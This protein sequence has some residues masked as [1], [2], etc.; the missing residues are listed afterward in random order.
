MPDSWKKQGSA[1]NLEKTNNIVVNSLV[2]D[3]FTVRK[4]ANDMTVSSLNV[5]GN[6]NIKGF[7]FVIK[8]I[9]GNNL[10]ISNNITLDGH[11]YFDSS[12]NVFLKGF[13]DNSDNYFLGLNNSNPQATLDISSN[14]TQSIFVKTTDSVNKNVLANTKDDNGIMLYADDSQSSVYFFN[15][16]SN[17][18]SNIDNVPSLSLDYIKEGKLFKIQKINDTHILSKVVISDRETDNHIFDET[19]IIYDISKNTFKPDVY[20][21]NDIT[22]GNALTLV[23][24]D[25]LSNTILNISTPNKT[26]L[27]LYGG[28]N[29]NNIKKGMAILD[30]MSNEDTSNKNPAIMLVDGEKKVKHP[31]TLGINTFKPN[32]NDYILD[33]NGSINLKNN[34]IKIISDPS[35]EIINMSYNK[36]NF[37]HA[38][39]V[40][41]SQSITD[42]SFVAMYTNDGGENWNF[43]DDISANNLN[44]TFKFK[45]IYVLDNSNSLISTENSKFIFYSNDGGKKYNK[46]SQRGIENNKGIYIT[47]FDGG[48]A[49]VFQAGTFDNITNQITSFTLDFNDDVGGNSISS[50]NQPNVGNII[51][52]DGYEKYFYVVGNDGLNGNIKRYDISNNVYDLTHS[53]SNFNYKK[54]RVLNKDTAIAIGNNII[55][56]TNDGSNWTDISN[57]QCQFNDV[58][59]LDNKRA[60]AVGENSKMYFAKNGF[61]AS[62]NLLDE[63]YLNG[64]GLAFQVLDA[65]CNI[66]NVFMSD[67]DSIVLS[68]VKSKFETGVQGKTNLIKMFLP[69]TL[70]RTNNSNLDMFGNIDISGDIIFNDGGKIRSTDKE[71]NILNEDVKTINIGK[72]TERINLGGNN[73]KLFIEGVFDDSINVTNLSVI[74]DTSL[75][76]IYVSN[77]ASFNSKV[78]VNQDVSFNSTLFVNDKTTLNETEI[79]KE[80]TAKKDV[81]LNSNI[82]II[83]GIINQF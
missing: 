3:E 6:V 80:I 29:P 31:K 76:N 38:I 26:G 7:L 67:L 5:D 50:I 77:D 24:N 41:S 69:D 60:I 74:N 33:I 15:D 64:S 42:G 52:L 79:L 16:T 57:V 14:S 58:F 11:L 36:N 72:E 13:T 20:K 73:T 27:N 9:N 49:N 75:N 62:W 23:S 39:A 4:F 83:T 78:F 37:N 82:N 68:S 59:I 43:S 1:N 44:S 48:F 12:N 2:C 35:F 22:Y 34:N 65:S 46:L 55:S 66:S 51:S 19:S 53:I 81:T 54:I 28:A 47:P 30:V 25:N 32:Y 40:G 8:D 10:D 70:N 71:F 45:S 63:S 61:D 18:L 17:N 56:F 21:N